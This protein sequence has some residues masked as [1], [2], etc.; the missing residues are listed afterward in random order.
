MLNVVGF[1]YRS[2]CDVN[3][4]LPKLCHLKLMALAPYSHTFYTGVAVSGL[5]L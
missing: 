3:H 2:T 1:F 5:R 4:Q